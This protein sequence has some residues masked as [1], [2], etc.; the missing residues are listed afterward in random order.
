MIYLNNAA[1]S[2]PKPEIVISAVQKNLTTVPFHS[3]RSGF[4]E[5]VE[6]VQDECRKNLA[7]L[8][9]IK[10]HNN[11]IFTSGATESLNL[12]LFGLNLKNKHVIT[13]NSEHNSVIRPLKL[14]ESSKHIKISFALCDE[15][16]VVDIDSLINLIQDNTALIVI[17]HCSNVTGNVNNIES[18]CAI[19]NKKKIVSLIDASQSAGIIPIDIEKCPVDML[20]F[21]GHKSLFGIRGIGGIFIKENLVIK[22][23]KV[24]GTGVR[25]DLLYQP[26]ERPI[27]FEAG[28]PNILGITSLLAGTRFVLEN[29]IANIIDKENKIFLHLFERLSQIDGVVT[30]GNYKTKQR[31]P[32]VSFNIKGVSPEDAG[33]ILESSYDIIIRSGLHCAPLIHESLGTYPRGSLR[34][35]LSFFTKDEEIDC[36]IDAVKQ[37]SKMN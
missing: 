31:C 1:T 8:F 36:F 26:K 34:V 24:G 18:V 3:G 15:D 22:P 10:N 33:F 11:I 23:L 2:Y 28:T 35:S 12:A 4:D 14:L 6:N 20:V 7:V 29:G 21:T 32:I 16:G 37:I 27:F 25:S 5:G 30:Y 13:T 17:N 9:N 19:C